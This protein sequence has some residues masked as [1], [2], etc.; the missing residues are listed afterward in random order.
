MCPEP[1]G[2]L[3]SIETT[4]HQDLNGDG[5]IGVVPVTIETSGSTSLVQ[6]SS[7]YFLDPLAG[8]TGV[9][10][11]YGGV[12]FVAGQFGTW[13][14]LGAE[15]TSSGY[16][17]AWKN[18]ASGLYTVWSTDNNGNFTSNLLSN[19]SGTSAA[20]ESIEN[21]LH[22]DLNGDGIIDTPATVI[23]ATGHVQVTLSHMTQA[24]TIDAGAT[25]ELTG[26]DSGV[27]YVQWCNR[28]FSS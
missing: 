15:A 22:Q 3:E 19:V 4:F 2:L 7:N 23:E 17:V 25:L 18:T 6:V 21:T 9:T 12:P 26:A 8:G 16:D 10:V 1:A 14:P 11:E 5:V 24:A 13:V 28:H 20:F 27:D